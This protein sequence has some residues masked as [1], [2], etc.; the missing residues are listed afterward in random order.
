M[1]L[2]LTLLLVMQ[3]ANQFVIY[4]ESDGFSLDQN[5]VS[6]SLAW[7]DNTNLLGSAT[8]FEDSRFGDVEQD[9]ARALRS[10]SEIPEFRIQEISA[11]RNGQ[12]DKTTN[13][14]LVRDPIKVKMVTSS[15][16]KLVPSFDISGFEFT[17]FEQ[18]GLDKD[19]TM[20]DFRDMLRDMV[21]NKRNY[22]GDDYNVI[23]TNPFS[24]SSENIMVRNWVWILLGRIR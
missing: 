24:K 6:V 20:D 23:I 15:N 16:Q 21:Q 10:S 2:I 9:S 13:E 14:I 22:L 7:N 1:V 18:V 8:Q 19:F 12:R 11:F 3:M 17:N 4:F 5:E